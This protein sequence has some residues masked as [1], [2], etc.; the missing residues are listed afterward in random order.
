[1][2]NNETP[3][4]P[5]SEWG[6]EPQPA[7]LSAGQTKAAI[8]RLRRRIA[9]LENFEP[10]SVS[11]GDDPRINA[12]ELTIRGTLSQVFGK[13]TEDYNRYIDAANINRT[14][15]RHRS[16]L[17][18]NREGLRRGKEAAIALLSVAVRLMEDHIGGINETPPDPPPIAASR[19]GREIFIVHGHDSPAKI[20]VARF[21]E[22]AGLIATILHEQTDD[23][24]TVIEKFEAHG[25]AA[26]FAI[27]LLTPDDVGGPSAKQLR[28]RARQNVIG[29]MFWFAGSSGVPASM[30]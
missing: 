24:R 9:E 20:E 17:S 11:D 5:P 2:T 30:P 29:E 6:P 14:P 25:G 28:P 19:A 22:R 1:M 8:C 12:L 16:I 10:D 21:I 13:E 18:Y 7:Q 23:G 3:P 26:G 27:V 15:L 4:T